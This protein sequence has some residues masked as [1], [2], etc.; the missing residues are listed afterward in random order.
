[1][2]QGIAELQI[3]AVAQFLIIPHVSSAAEHTAALYEVLRSISDGLDIWQR[4]R[5]FTHY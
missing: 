5:K 1:M 2:L 4:V 3:P